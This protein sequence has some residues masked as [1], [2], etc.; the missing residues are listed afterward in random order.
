[1][2]FSK[3]NP[4]DASTTRCSL[5]RI[6]LAKEVLPSHLVTAMDPN[7]HLISN[8]SVKLRM[9]SVPGKRKAFRIRRFDVLVL[10]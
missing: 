5:D 8:L 6:H 1:M 3:S 10:Q 2:L 7:V 9:L 4:R